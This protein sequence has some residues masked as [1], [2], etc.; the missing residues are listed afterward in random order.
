M[1]FQPKHLGDFAQL[2]GFRSAKDLLILA[3]FSSA[4]AGGDVVKLSL[5]DPHSVLML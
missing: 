4:S 1:G 2:K 5:F 3:A